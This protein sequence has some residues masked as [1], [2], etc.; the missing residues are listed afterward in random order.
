MK[1]LFPPLAALALAFAT[2]AAAQRELPDFTRLVEEQGPAV[3]NI[4]TTQVRRAPQALPQIPGMEGEE[5]QEF[6]RRFIPR[7]P[8]Q[9]SEEHT[10][11]LQ[12]H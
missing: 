10:S 7:Q 2:P 1:W 3:V 12:S 9:R 11:E 6:F 4:S 5:G 8:Q